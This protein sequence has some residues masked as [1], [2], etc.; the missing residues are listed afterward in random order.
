MIF[1]A[2]PIYWYTGV[3]L[4]LHGNTYANNSL[5][6]ITSIGETDSEEPNNNTALQCVTD[7]PLCC[8][9]ARIGE[10]YFPNGTR[11]SIRGYAEASQFYRNRGDDGAINL[12]RPSNVVMPTGRFCCVVPDATDTIQHVCANIGEFVQ[13]IIMYMIH[14]IKINLSF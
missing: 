2:L 11:V 12:N 1:H 8:R 4:S 14:S 5:I 9:S 7:K 13:M 3:Y 10:W 6:T